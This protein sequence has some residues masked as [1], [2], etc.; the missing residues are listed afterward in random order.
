[1]LALMPG[2]SRGSLLGQITLL[3]ELIS[4]RLEPAL[5]EVGLSFGTFEL[6]SAVKAGNGQRTQ[7]ELADELGITAP[8][9]CEAVQAGIKKGWLTQVAGQTDRRTKFVG[10]TSTGDHA[11]QHV[12]SAFRDLENEIAPKL[13]T[14]E[15]ETTLKALE[16]ARALLQ[17]GAP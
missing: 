2:E 8:S 5:R 9:L 11:V 12:L 4:A 17:V 6:L 16:K 3:N 1:M 10:L 14:K 13:G 15:I 7:I